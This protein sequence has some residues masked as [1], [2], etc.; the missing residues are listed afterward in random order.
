LGTTHAV[1]E[2]LGEGEGGLSDI[3]CLSGVGSLIGE[4]G[5]E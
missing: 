5:G 4:T 2:M 1:S 3:G